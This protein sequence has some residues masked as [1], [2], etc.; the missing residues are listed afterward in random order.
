MLSTENMAG[1]GA[2]LAV[3]FALPTLK[4]WQQHFAVPGRPD[5][6]ATLDLIWMSARRWERSPWHSDRAYAV[7]PVGPFVIALKILF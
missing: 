2:A 1:D 6:C 3:P 7:F 4:S 5:T